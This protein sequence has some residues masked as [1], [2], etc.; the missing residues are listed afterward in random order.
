LVFKGLIEQN[1]PITV[2]PHTGTCCRSIST[3]VALCGSGVCQH[4]C[5]TFVSHKNAVFQ[6][7]LVSLAY[8]DSFL[9]AIPLNQRLASNLLPATQCH[10]ASGDIRSEESVLTLPV[11]KTT[12]N[13]EAIK[14]VPACS[15]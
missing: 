12:H 2:C 13:A 15:L 8:A 7:V 10:I 9:N 11:A 4:N 5:Q 3:A 1:V 6:K 14:S